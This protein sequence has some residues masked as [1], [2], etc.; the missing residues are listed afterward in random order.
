MYILCL[1]GFCVALLDIWRTI[2]STAGHHSP[3]THF[4]VTRFIP[5]L[6]TSVTQILLCILY[7]GHYAIIQLCILYFT[8]CKYT[9]L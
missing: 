8:L 5:S 2:A 9:G 3:V 4:S 6:H 7:V 1:V